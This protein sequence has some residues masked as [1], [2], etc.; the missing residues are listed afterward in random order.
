MSSGTNERNY[1]KD[2]A[3]S[4]F[5][6]DRIDLSFELDP[7]ETVVRA[8]MHLRRNPE[9]RTSDAP[10]VLQGDELTLRSATLDGHLLDDARF[11]AD[12]QSLRVANVPDQFELETEVVI[13]PADNTKLM[14]LY[15][16]SDTFCTQC[17]AEGFRRITYYLDRPDVMARFTTRIEAD[18]ARY[19]VLLSNGNRVGEGELPNGR[20]WVQWEDPFPKPSYLFALVAGDLVCHRGTFTTASGREVALEIWVEPQN[21]TSASTRS[22]RFEAAMKWDEDDLRSRVRPRHLHDRRR[23]RLQH[24]RDGEQGAQ[25]LQLEVRARQA[26]DRDRRRLRGHR[27]RRRARVFPQLDRQPR[28]LPRLVSAHAQGRAD[29]LSRSGVLGRHDLARRASASR[30]SRVC[31]RPSSPKTPAHSRIRFGPS[32]TSR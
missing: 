10:L 16:S 26:I 14:G 32:R 6:A 21:A 19:P 12:S 27:E 23:Q 2:Y 13:R 31:A 24:G 17:E 3:P 8:K 25:R 7:D 11:E 20:H 22:R 29:R 5:L 1:R 9:A 4:E 30:T 15:T 18:R 28:H